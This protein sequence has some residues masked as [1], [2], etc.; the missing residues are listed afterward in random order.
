MNRFEH[1]GNEI[2][3][4]ATNEMTPESEK[5]R[6]QSFSDTF[7]R[8]GYFFAGYTSKRYLKISRG[9]QAWPMGH[10]NKS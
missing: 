7:V 1:S 6:S 3:F 4:P 10:E 2:I 8:C 5:C 9:P